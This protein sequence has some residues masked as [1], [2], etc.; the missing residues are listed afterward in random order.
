MC[1]VEWTD[2]SDEKSASAWAIGR[3]GTRSAR[4]VNAKTPMPVATI[5]TF[6]GLGLVF[7]S[8]GFNQAPTRLEFCTTFAKTAN[9]ARSEG[10]ELTRTLI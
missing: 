6:L 7:F 1:L 5:T 8:T 4:I 2:G 9:A 10:H 3:D